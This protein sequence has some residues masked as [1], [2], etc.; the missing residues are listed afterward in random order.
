[1]RRDV[2]INGGRLLSSLRRRSAGTKRNA[3]RAALC[4]GFGSS[5]RGALSGA[6]RPSGAFLSAIPF[7]GVAFAVATG[8]PALRPGTRIEE[9]PSTMAAY[10]IPIFAFAVI[11]MMILRDAEN[12]KRSHPPRKPPPSRAGDSH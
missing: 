1:M 8:G 6:P 10:I 5:E 12:Y 11:L 2:F 7:I 4:S 3:G 9:E